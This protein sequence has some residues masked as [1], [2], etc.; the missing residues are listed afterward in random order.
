MSGSGQSVEYYTINLKLLVVLCL[1]LRCVLVVL[2]SS[3]D[4][5]C[6]ISTIV[7]A[8]NHS[9]YTIKDDI[10][11]SLARNQESIAL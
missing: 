6:A 5:L 3:G 7:K 11:L 4:H 8:Y 10:R 1:M 9:S 2:Q